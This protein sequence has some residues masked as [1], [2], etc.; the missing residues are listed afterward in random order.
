M[1]KHVHQ[2][3]RRFPEVRTA[4]SKIGRSEIPNAPE[5]P[6]ESDPV[7]LLH[8]KDSWTTAKTKSDLVDAI[9]RELADVPGISVLMSQPIQERVDELISGMRTEAAV[10]LFGDDL[11]IL[12]EKAD[13]IAS[14]M[15]TIAGVKD[16]KVEQIAGQPYLTVDID[17]NK[18]ARHGINVADIQELIETAIGGKPATHVYEGARRFQLILRFPKEYRNRVGAIGEIRVKAAA[19]ALTPMSDLATI[20]LREGPARISREQARRRIYIGFNVVGRDI[21]GVVDEGR[22]KLAES[23]RLPQGYQIVW[24]GSFENMERAME[25][26]ALVVPITIGLIFLLLFLTFHSWRYATLIILNIPFALTGGVFSLWLTGQYL[27]MPAS[28]GFIELF[29]LAVGNG[30]LLVSYIHQ[31]RREGRSADEATV[32]GCLLRLRPVLMTMLTTLLGLFPLAIAQGIGAEVQRPLA[33][34]VIGGLFTSTLLT[35]V[36][37]LALYR[38]FEDRQAQASD[39]G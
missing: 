18:I 3:L 23:V 25:R 8:T 14:I 37:L 2:V 19:G 20:D 31:L 17:R 26:L 22:R 32:T 33:T 34:V 24:G 13:E 15:Q 27:S 6:N 12:K 39:I 7:V 30:I 36:L 16:V 5:E 9:R 10:K 29:A 4:V 35:L 38:W 21:G 28:I 1:E 11:E